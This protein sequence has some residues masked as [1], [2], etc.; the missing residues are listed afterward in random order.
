MTLSVSA[1]VCA[2][3]SE[4]Y[5]AETLE[6]IV[7][8]TRRPDEII[9][10][11]DGSTDSSAEILERFTPEVRVV[12]QANGGIGRARNAGIA[13]ASG[14][15]VAFCDA[16]DLWDPTK[17]E[18]QLRVFERDPSVDVVFT[19]VHEFVSPDIDPTDKQ[20]RP[21]LAHATGPLT[22]TMLV[23]RTVFDRVGGFDVERRVG[24]WMEWYMRLHD[25]GARE[26]RLGMALVHRRLHG[27]NNSM[28]ASLS[29]EEYLN[30]VKA[31]LDRTRRG[32]TP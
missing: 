30:V 8:Q 12:R 28:R 31:H 29:R 27:E 22:S 26:V 5:V 20:L 11:D 18:R 10:I 9:A 3:N 4:R 23:R 24:D 25:A 17:L 7:A 13:E 15:L 19:A 16:D 32:L 6:H 21:V 2:Y 14:D 1:I